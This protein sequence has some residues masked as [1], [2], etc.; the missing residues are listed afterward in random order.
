M[1]KSQN[2]NIQYFCFKF[3][4]FREVLLSVFSVKITAKLQPNIG[5]LLI[6]FNVSDRDQTKCHASNIFFCL[7]ML[8]VFHFELKFF[9]N[10]NFALVISY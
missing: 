10:S 7:V 3:V 5:Q 6:E 9:I 4:P 2:R 1:K 8:S